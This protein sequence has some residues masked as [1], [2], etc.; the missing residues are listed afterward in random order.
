MGQLS[1]RTPRGN[2]P[3]V[4]SR[5]TVGD[6]RVPLIAALLLLTAC[7][8]ARADEWHTLRPAGLE[9]TEVAA[10]RVGDAF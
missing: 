6:M 3:L 7:G 5:A 2:P 4:R 10:A 8:S 9:R 1:W